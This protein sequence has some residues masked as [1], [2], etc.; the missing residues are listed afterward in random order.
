MKKKVMEKWVKALRS[1]KYEQG[2][3]KLYSALNDEY[4]CLGVLCEIAPK[5][6]TKVKKDSDENLSAYPLVKKWAEIKDDN[7]KIPYSS[8]TILNDE[9]ASFEEIADIIEQN[10]KKL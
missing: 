4:C 5:S 10:W 9:G 2:K 6:Y 7:C 1:G 3:N 8:L